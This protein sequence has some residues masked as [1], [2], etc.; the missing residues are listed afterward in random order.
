MK[1]NFI[2]CAICVLIADLI[3]FVCVFL[4]I[5]LSPSE[6]RPET[7]DLFEAFFRYKFGNNY[8]QGKNTDA[9]YYYLEIAGKDPS[10]EFMVRFDGH[11]P[12][13]KKGSEFVEPELIKIVDVESPD[14]EPMD[15]EVDVENGILFQ[16]HSCKWVGLGWITR[17]SVEIYGGYYEGWLSAS[18]NSYIWVRKK[19]KWTLKSK[20]KGWMAENVRE[21]KKTPAMV[22]LSK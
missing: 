18:R 15:L 12:P 2:K 21:P 10:P 16:I 20:G 6:N 13:V 17:N 4:V 14:A 7:L 1:L 8:S 3:L 9:Y 19:G 5:K 22:T 11:S